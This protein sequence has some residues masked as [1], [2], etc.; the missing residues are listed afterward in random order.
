M[1]FL[2]VTNFTKLE[3]LHWAASRALAVFRPPLSH[4]FSLR[5]LYLPCESLWLISLFHFMSGLFVS[6]PPFPFQ[7]WPDLEWNQGSADCPGELLRS[8]TRSCFLLLV[9]GR[10]FLLALTFLEPAFLHCGVLPF[11]SMLSLWSSSLSPRCSSR[12]PW[13]S[14]PSWPGALDG[15]ICSF[16][17]W[18]RRLRRTCQ[19]LSLWHLIWFPPRNLC[20]LVMLAV[21]SLI[22]AATD[23]A[24]C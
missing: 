15:Q 11:P 14:P 3:R 21:F 12:T 4:F 8:L 19:L 7:V 22:Y 13:L 1:I 9:L 24:F 18:Q 23:T 17:F 2:S 16:S 6:Q 20:S 10:L 5:L